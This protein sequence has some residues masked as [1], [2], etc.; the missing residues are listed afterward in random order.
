MRILAV[1]LC[2]ILAGVAVARAEDALSPAQSKQVEKIIHDY[3][4]AHPEVLVEAMQAAEDKAKA[5]KDAAAEKNIRAK[6]ADIFDDPASPVGG[7]PHGN[8][9]LVEFFDYR[10]PYCKQVEPD[11]EALVRDD[12]QL[13]I[14]YKE[15]PILGADSVFASHIA[16]AAIKQGK[17]PAFH[18]AMMN[19]KGTIDEAVILKV[20][21]SVGIDV[22]KAK[23]DLTAPEVDAMIKKNFNLA[24][25]LDIS[26]TP[27]FVIGGKLVPGAVNKNTLKKL[28]DEARHSG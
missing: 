17:Y 7:N 26:G 9:T 4:V 6:H 3:L 28:I 19:T 18:Q 8:V 21:N 12:P 15:Y 16:I 14:V 1:L 11:L 22:A 5:D 13:R 10:C 23:T 25:T 2:F 24:E 20:A 27:A